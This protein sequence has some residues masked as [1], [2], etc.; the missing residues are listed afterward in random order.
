MKR[1][2]AL[3]KVPPQPATML[4]IPF[5]GCRAGTW[6]NVLVIVWSAPATGA[7]VA[8][9]AKVTQTLKSPYGERWTHIHIIREGSG[10]PTA[11]ASKGF[12]QIMRQHEQRLA[13][14]AVMV[15]GG[16]FWASTMR[17]MITSMR[18][19]SPRSFDLRLHGTVAELVAWLPEAHAERTGVEI[20]RE[21]LRTLLDEA[22]GWGDDTR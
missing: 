16:G 3:Q 9:L 11:E 4:D 6:H 13:N 7:I 14:V 10:L 2:S 8:H 21:Q 15:G 19:L 22:Y 18:L 1:S 20:E 12:V 17:S 5:S